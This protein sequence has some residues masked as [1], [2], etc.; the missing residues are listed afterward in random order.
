MQKLFFYESIRIPSVWSDRKQE[1]P[2]ARLICPSSG[3]LSTEDEVMSGN[4][5]LKDQLAALRWVHRNI[6]DFGGDPHRLTLFGESAGG[7]SSHILSLSPRA[8]G[9]I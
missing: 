4:Y 3:F 9:E 1:R 6:R 7:T 8:Q 2:D 5:M